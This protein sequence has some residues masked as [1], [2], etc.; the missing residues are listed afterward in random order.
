MTPSN[1]GIFIF[2]EVEVL[3]FAGP[4]EVFSR[5]RLVPG[6]DSR[7]GSDSAPFHVFTVARSEDAIRAI[8][9]LRIL[10][11]HSWRSAPPIDIL[12]IPGGFGTRNLLKD[13]LAI[14]WVRSAANQASLV[15][16]VCTGALLLAQAGLLRGRHAT[17]HWAACD[18]LAATDPTIVVERGVRV[19][20]DTVITSAGVS[21]GMD[22]AFDVVELRCGRD[23]AKETADYIEYRRLDGARDIHAPLLARAASHAEQYLSAIHERHVGA[24]ASGDDLRQLLRRPLSESGEESGQVIDDLARAGQNGT[25]ASQGPRYFGFVTGGSLPVATAA[26]WLVSA[27]D[28]NAQVYVMSP[29]AAVVEEIASDWLKDLMGLPAS[30][31]VGFVTGAQTANFT[32]LLAA[33]HHLLRNVDW[34]VERDGLFGAPAIDVIVSDEAHRTIFTALRMLGLGGERLRRVD[35]DGQGRMRT[36]RL[37]EL[38]RGATGP[39]VVCTQVGNVN[40]GAADPLAEIAP[41]TRSRGAWLHV[42]AAFGLWAAVSPSL[43]HLVAGVEQ[44]DS[45]ATDG[46]KWLNVPYD[47]GI[48]FTAHPES[49]QRALL[50]PAHYIQMTP[51]ERDPRAFTPDESRRARGVTM[52]AALRTLGRRGLRELVE[53]CCAHARRMAATLR[54]HAQ[55]RVLNEIVLNQVLVQFVPLASDPRDE[56]AF[57]KEVVAGVQSDGT[58]WLGSTQWQGRRA[59]RISICN[60]STTEQDIDRSAAAILRTIE[61]LNVQ[62]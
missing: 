6:A 12:V 15:T 5:T 53:R 48:V 21:A 24:L 38:L 23:V 11:Q 16:S 44:A 25:T 45:I 10:P 39:C 40:T 56:S 17:T 49:H 55:V 31:S 62:I 59:A 32:A 2:D 47:S 1:V 20:H 33:R 30:W 22:M 37:S 34:D 27:W 8:G 14:D 46:H 57:T 54:Q 18:L 35:T 26:D 51:G 42:D 52:Y 3:D 43:R 41:L 60:W 7:R 50:M 13:K 4:F 58:C 9:G 28:Q 29:V 61:Q 19:V 36:D